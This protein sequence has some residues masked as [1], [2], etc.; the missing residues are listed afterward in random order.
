MLDKPVGLPIT[1]KFTNVPQPA[2]IVP[3]V[4]ENANTKLADAFIINPAD[5]DSPPVALF[6]VAPSTLN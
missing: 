1:S 5:E 3:A 6:T 4:I 2:G